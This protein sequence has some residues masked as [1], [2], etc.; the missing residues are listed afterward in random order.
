M[1]YPLSHVGNQQRK[2]D[3]RRTKLS[4]KNRI[5]CE[6]YYLTRIKLKHEAKEVRFKLLL[7]FVYLLLSCVIYLQKF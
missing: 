4:A 1:L 2:N 3:V 7:L 6:H 5:L